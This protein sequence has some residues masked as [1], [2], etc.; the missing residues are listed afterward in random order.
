MSR[1]ARKQYSPQEKVAILREHLLEGKAVSEVRRLPFQRRAETDSPYATEQP[2][3]RG[4]MMQGDTNVDTK[5]RFLQVC[6]H[7]VLAAGCDRIRF[8]ARPGS[9]RARNRC[10][11]FRS[12]ASLARLP[13]Q[14]SRRWCSDC[15]VRMSVQRASEANSRPCGF[16]VVS[17]RRDDGAIVRVS[18]LGSAARWKGPAIYPARHVANQH[19]TA[20]SAVDRARP[21]ASGKS[22]A[23]PLRRSMP[24]SLAPRDTGY[25]RWLCPS[26]SATQRCPF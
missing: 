16:R 23:C 5:R 19:P 21:N 15:R 20:R 7:L 24:R 13:R 3:Q 14:G 11:S 2:G 4:A 12:I 22:P 8:L 9:R 18:D 26:D 1:K 6:C 10:T 17:P 25:H